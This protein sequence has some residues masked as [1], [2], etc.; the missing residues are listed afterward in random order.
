MSKVT[1]FL[2]AGGRV[3]DSEEPLLFY[4]SGNRRANAPIASGSVKGDVGIEIEIEGARLPT[5]GVLDGVS[6][7]ISKAV[8]NC[9]EDG[10]LRGGYEYRTSAA[11]YAAE[12]APM[13]TQFFERCAANRSKINLSNR[14]SLHVHLNCQGLKAH[15]ITSIFT[16]WL[17][18]EEVLVSWWGEERKTNHFCLTSN[19]Q[20]STVDFWRQFLKDGYTPESRNLKYSSL[21]FLTLFSFGSLE[22]RCGGGINSAEKG[23]MWAEFLHAFKQYC[24]NTFQNPQEIAYAMSERGAVELFKD[25]CLSD[26]VSMGQQFFDEVTASVEGD[27][28]DI[29]LHG[30][31]NAQPFV[32]EHDWDKIIEQA[33]KPNVVDPFKKKDRIGAIL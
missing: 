22:V 33:A 11:I 18:F 32:I 2:K 31:R 23:I 12:I 13:L 5:T 25:I 14:C 10:S 30:F 9:V 27:F 3:G 1:E 6:G 17:A 20:N 24:L 15:E 21:N 16:L 8:W 19:N 7:E 26:G 28:H 4:Q 29:C